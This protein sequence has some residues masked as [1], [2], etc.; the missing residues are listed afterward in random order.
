MRWALLATLY[1]IG[2]L[3]LGLLLMGAEGALAS[4][5]D[6]VFLVLAIVLFRFALKDTSAM[7]DI[8]S[9]ERERAELRLV[10]IALAAVFLI[11]AAVLGY[12]ML[13]ALF[14]FL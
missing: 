3:A 9:D 6:V 4:A 13:K 2:V 14:G 10:Q 5:L 1:L 8:A 12:G 7:L 11:T